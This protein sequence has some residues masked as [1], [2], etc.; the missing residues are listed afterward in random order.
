MI[1]NPRPTRAETADVANAI[2]DGTSAIMLSGETAAGSYPV[3]AV[4]TMSRIA[5]RTEGD[6]DYAHQFK[7]REV[8]EAFD[9]TN[10]IAH[11]TVTT[12]TDLGAA[13]I[14]TVTKSG[15]TA[16]LMSKFRP[17][18]PII[19]CTPIRWSAARPASP[20]AWFPDYGGDGQ[21]TDE[22]FEHSVEAAVR[23]G[24]VQSGD[25]VVITAGLPVNVSG[26]T[27]LLKVH[28]VGDVLVTGQGI[29]G[30]TAC[31]NLC[32]CKDEEEALRK[33]KR[34]DILVIPKT[35]NHLLPF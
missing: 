32:V 30:N 11:A 21:C 29:N 25:L 28:I 8:S 2:Y 16:R 24:L 27:N 4:R 19:S 15:Q 17:S 34:G 20:G 18:A 12:A 22:L 9:V 5:E 23:A 31:A 13:A 6:I 1:K 7:G 10:A 14:I 3:E 26:T 33:C 35:S